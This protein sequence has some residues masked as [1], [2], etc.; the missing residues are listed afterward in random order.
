MPYYQQNAAQEW[1]RNGTAPTHNDYPKSYP[2]YGPGGIPLAMENPG[3]TLPSDGYSAQPSFVN[4]NVSFGEHD[5]LHGNLMRVAQ[6]DTYNS[7]VGPFPRAGTYEEP[8]A[9]TAVLNMIRLAPTTSAH[10]GLSFSTGA[11][12]T[13]LFVAPPVF[14]VQS[15]PIYA[16]GL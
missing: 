1:P 3:S 12:P 15:T 5:G 16:T 10:P 13:M 11:G 8:G 7:A 2:V 9:A 6:A 14:S 4:V